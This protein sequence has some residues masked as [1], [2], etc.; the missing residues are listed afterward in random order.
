V[1]T[2]PPGA[3]DLAITHI[4]WQRRD[5]DNEPMDDLIIGLHAPHALDE[6]AHLSLQLKHDLAWGDSPNNKT[7]RAVIRAAWDTFCDP[8]KG[9]F[10]RHGVVVGVEKSDFKSYREVIQ[11]A[12]DCQ[13]GS[14]FLRVIGRGAAKHKSFVALIRKVLDTFVQADKPGSSLSDDELWKFLKRF[15][16]LQFDLLESD[17]KDKAFCCSNMQMGLA[18][19]TP[20]AARAMWNE[21]AGIVARS[22]RNSGSCDRET[23][24]EKLAPH[25]RTRPQPTDVAESP[26]VDAPVTMEKLAALFDSRLANQTSALG[27]LIK[28]VD[29]RPEP[30]QQ[31]I[32]EER[33]DAQVDTARGLIQKGY[34]RAA[35]QA[36]NTIHADDPLTSRLEFRIKANLG[37]C[38]SMLDE[39][40]EAI[41]L[42]REA[43]QHDKEN[44]K[45]MII[46]A[47]AE[48]LDGQLNAALRLCESAMAREP[49]LADAASIYA[50]ALLEAGRYADLRSWVN[51]EPWVEDE[52]KCAPHLARLDHHEGHIDA[53]IERLERFQKEANPE[54]DVTFTLAWLLLTRPYDTWKKKPLLSW[55]LPARMRRDLNRSTELYQNIIKARGEF[56]DRRQSALCLTNRAVALM[57]LNRDVEAQKDLQQASEITPDSPTVWINIGWLHLRNEKFEESVVA[58]EKAHAL[59]EQEG[60]D[61]EKELG[62]D[63]LRWENTR[64]L[65]VALHRTDR[66]DRLRV[67]LA[68]LIRW[69]GQALVDEAGVPLA[70]QALTYDFCN[71]L[72]LWLQAQDPAAPSGQGPLLE[73]QKQFSPLQNDVSAWLEHNFPDHP[74]VLALRGDLFW[75]KRRFRDAIKLMRRAVELLPKEHQDRGKLV[76]AEA[77]FHMR[78]YRG[79]VPLFKATVSEFVINSHLK[80]YA[81]AL[82]RSGN[83]EEARRIAAHVRNMGRKGGEQEGK[84]VSVFSEIEAGCAQF[85]GD[86]ALALRLRRGLM[87]QEPGRK[88]HALEVALLELELGNRQKAQAVLGAISLVHPEKDPELALRFAHAKVELRL[89]GA[90]ELGFQIWRAFPHNARYQVAYTTLFQSIT[91]ENDPMLRPEVVGPDCAVTLKTIGSNQPARTRLLLRHPDAQELTESEGDLSHPQWQALVGKRVGDRVTIAHQ[92]GGD[93]EVEVT[94]I[95]HKFVYAFQETIHRLER[96]DITHEGFQVSDIEAEGGKEAWLRKMTKMMLQNRQ[97][98]ELLEEFYRRHPIP[99]SVVGLVKNRFT[100]ELWNDIGSAGRR[101][102]SSDAGPEQVLQDAQALIGHQ[103]IALDVTALGC[104]CLLGFEV[105][106]KRRFSRLLVPQPVREELVLHLQ[107]E[108]RDGAASAY[109]THDGLGLRYVEVDPKA[110]E[111]RIE[112]IERVLGFV[113]REC[114]VVPVPSLLLHSKWV[115]A[116]GKGAVASVLLAHER[117]V[118]MWSDDARLRKFGADQFGIKTT[119]FFPL[120]S[121]LR[122][123]GLSEEDLFSALCRLTLH[124]YTYVW[125]PADVLIWRLRQDSL[126]LTNEARFLLFRSFNGQD[127]NLKWAAWELS[128]FIERLWNQQPRL[129]ESQFRPIL[130]AALESYVHRRST[131]LAIGELQKT[132]RGFFRYDYSSLRLLLNDIARWQ[133]DELRV[134][135]Y[136]S[137]FEI[138]RF[139]TASI[140]QSLIIGHPHHRM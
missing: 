31:R 29:D 79:C 32:E 131:K 5:V 102:Y 11:K 64:G 92:F 30:S 59:F 20:G 105:A 34:A 86:L 123:F 27:A 99:L 28:G 60:I 35:R 87:E 62:E 45:A 8:K 82:L 120:L 90:L 2:S 23:L 17:S 36:L 110:H 85:A 58:H 117:Q 91:R 41:R 113:D 9:Q 25:L 50:Q 84:A 104:I 63:G 21:I 94:E 81:L 70:A 69:N 18:L 80:H 33:I 16:L 65:A 61:D 95:R 88:D 138:G 83:L 140:E 101:F 46:G 6:T 132:L 129:L 55:N 24:R 125:V 71:L 14:D 75:F 3:N 52:A 133:K 111:Q 77:L 26:Q 128:F 38:A 73:V 115:T 98:W 51:H 127:V 76:L 40:D 124:G 97:G 121:H 74:E 56:D 19:S 22:N 1:G 67:H 37:V 12:Q 137:Q 66:W 96:G 107:R 53:A 126:K 10:D 116:I 114:E 139:E 106:T 42:C 103:E 13:S 118:P 39:N 68:S 122:P 136:G 78:R 44:P 112:F 108:N 100:L 109:L 135:D 43:F 47:Q 7:F 93:V 72:G 119:Y 54:E 130:H 89:P 57:L 15:C 49:K 4:K 48:L 134:V